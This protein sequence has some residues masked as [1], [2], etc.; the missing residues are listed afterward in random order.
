MY[1]RQFLFNSPHKKDTIWFF[2]F[3]GLFIINA[4]TELLLP[5]PEY[6]IRASGIP[7]FYYTS[8]VYTYIFYCFFLASIIYCVSLIIKGFKA[9]SYTHLD[10][11][12]RQG[13]TSVSYADDY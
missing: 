3:V 5:A 6:T 4:T 11:Y 12:K 10:V 7:A 9:V 2:L 1:K 13:V 8:N